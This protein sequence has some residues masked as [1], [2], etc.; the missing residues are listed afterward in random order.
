MGFLFLLLLIYLSGYDLYINGS[1]EAEN[2]TQHEFT[3]FM[4]MSVSKFPVA[5]RILPIRPGPS[6]SGGNVEG[7]KRRVKGRS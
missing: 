5:G 6:E 7:S 2:L 1:F 3:N 4:K